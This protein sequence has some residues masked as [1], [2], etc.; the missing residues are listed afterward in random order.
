MQGFVIAACDL[1]TL[2][3]EQFWSGS[4]FEEDIEN[5]AFYNDRA[6]ARYQLG[7]LQSKFPEFEIRL[8]KAAT[9]IVLSE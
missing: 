1:D 3:P 2:K 5:A 9:T 4:V 8:I 6:Q 7:G